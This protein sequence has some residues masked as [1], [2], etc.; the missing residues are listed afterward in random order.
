MPGPSALAGLSDGPMLPLPT[1]T[2]AS[3]QRP[4]QQQGAGGH[5]T[6]DRTFGCLPSPHRCSQAA[7]PHYPTAEPLSPLDSPALLVQ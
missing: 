7:Q 5:L 4:E 3:R 6:R 1:L 2:Q